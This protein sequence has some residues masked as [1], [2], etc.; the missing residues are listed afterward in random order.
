M[1]SASGSKECPEAEK[2]EHKAEQHE[3]DNEQYHNSHGKVLVVRFVP[4]YQHGERRARSA[5]EP[6]MLK[7]LAFGDASSFFYGVFFVDRKKRECSYVYKYYI[8]GK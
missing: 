5:A 3:L 4:V 1:F 8:C 2:A 6:Y 7:K